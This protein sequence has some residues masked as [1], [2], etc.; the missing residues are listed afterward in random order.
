M[1]EPGRTQ[2][3]N[4]QDYAFGERTEEFALAFIRLFKEGMSKDAAAIIKKKLLAHE[5]VDMSGVKMS[6]V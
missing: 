2:L 1:G 5:T 6:L 4:L 3:L